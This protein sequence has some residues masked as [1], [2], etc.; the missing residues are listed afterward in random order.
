MVCKSLHSV[1][2]YILNNVPTSPQMGFV[3]RK[4][5]KI[6]Y[7]TYIGNLYVCLICSY[8]FFPCGRAVVLKGHEA[9][10]NGSTDPSYT[11]N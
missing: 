8:S 7:V 10:K 5:A 11:A 9:T 3:Y 6:M 2:I 1:F 4:G